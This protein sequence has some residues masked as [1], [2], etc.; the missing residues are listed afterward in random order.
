MLFWVLAVVVTTPSDPSSL[1]SH[2]FEVNTSMCPWSHIWMTLSRLWFIFS[3][4]I[5]LFSDA[6]FLPKLIVPFPRILNELS[7]PNVIVPSFSC[8]HRNVLLFPV[9][10]LE[11][12]LSTHWWLLE[13]W[14]CKVILHS[15]ICKSS[16][17]FFQIVYC[18]GT[19]LVFFEGPEEPVNLRL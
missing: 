13:F 4:S 1:I 14:A 9:I 10:C 17:F 7:L 18:F 11:H 2:S 3:V 5:T 15:A 19:F 6:S 12:P 8:N 16:C